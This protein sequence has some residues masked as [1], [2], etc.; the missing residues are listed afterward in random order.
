MNTLITLFL[1][2]PA[3]MGA[4]ISPSEGKEISNNDMEAQ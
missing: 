3:A 2:A 1:A 4:A